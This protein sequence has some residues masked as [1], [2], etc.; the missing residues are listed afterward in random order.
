MIN[1]LFNVQN[2]VT[3]VL[4]DTLLTTNISFHNLS[5]LLHTQHVFVTI[6]KNTAERKTRLKQSAVTLSHHTLPCWYPI[7]RHTE[8]AS[9]GCPIKMSVLPTKNTCQ[10]TKHCNLVSELCKEIRTTKIPNN[11][12]NIVSEMR[13]ITYHKKQYYKAY[14][15]ASFRIKNPQH[16]Q[17]MSVFFQ[18]CWPL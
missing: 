6:Q 8:M 12:R 1:K 11:Y 18:G 16:K 4:S 10:L 13:N 14:E 17:L 5:S 2:C 9:T 7:S 15:N 3:N